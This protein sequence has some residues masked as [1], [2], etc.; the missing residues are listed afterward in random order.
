MHCIA[1]L[2]AQHQLL[3]Q[4]NA[5]SPGGNKLAHST[6]CI[7]FTTPKH[8]QLV[9]AAPVVPGRQEQREQLYH[10]IAAAQARLA[11]AQR[12]R[13]L[14]VKDLARAKSDLERCRE[15]AKGSKATR[16]RL[17]DG[18]AAEANWLAARPHAATLLTM[19][20]G[21]MSTEVSSSR[22]QQRVAG[23]MCNKPDL[24]LCGLA[25]GLQMVQA[26]CNDLW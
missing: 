2:T 14:A 25:A 20:A 6:A 23:R 19:T 21:P 10:A 24:C 12:R 22:G 7:H 5:A 3:Q 8:S 17:L 9:C 15:A 26:G 18:A 1:C 13:D 11:T 4:R 16:Q